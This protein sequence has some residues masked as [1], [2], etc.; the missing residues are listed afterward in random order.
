MSEQVFYLVCRV[1]PDCCEHLGLYATKAEAYHV[2]REDKQ[3]QYVD[4]E[5]ARRKYGKR[6]FDWLPWYSAYSHTIERFVVGVLPD[7]IVFWD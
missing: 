4:W 3:R 2:M 5:R 6:F 7:M 1:H